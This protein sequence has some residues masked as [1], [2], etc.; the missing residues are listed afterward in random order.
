[1]CKCGYWFDQYLTTQN[2][3]TQ[4]L[5][6]KGRKIQNKK[7]HRDFIKLKKYVQ[8][9]DK[10]KL[11]ERA[12]TYCHKWI[13]QRDKG[14]PCISCGAKTARQWH[15]SHYYDSGQ[16]SGLRYEESNIH[17]SCEVCNTHLHGNKVGYRKGLIDRYGIEY[18]LALE[19]KKDAGRF[20]KWSVDELTEVKNNYKQKT[21]DYEQ[22]S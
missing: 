20:K 13:K 21:K 3:C 1:M 16:F 12:K 15:A 2:K 17:K 4:C 18:V 5:I 8:S 22:K 6:E 14:L 9:T 10:K 11:A 7:D 19:A